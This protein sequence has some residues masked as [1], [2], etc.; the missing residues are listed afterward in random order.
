MITVRTVRRRAYSGAALMDFRKAHAAEMA[1]GRAGASTL[2]MGQ[3]GVWAANDEIVTLVTLGWDIGRVVST[4][5][6]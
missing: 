4:S 1:M 3:G 6:G 2:Q 5:R